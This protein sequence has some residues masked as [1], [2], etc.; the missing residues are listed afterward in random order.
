M[1][2]GVQ[3]V[4]AGMVEVTFDSFPLGMGFTVADEEEGCD[5]VVR[6]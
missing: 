2:N 1:W 4:T 3:A 6:R 5:A